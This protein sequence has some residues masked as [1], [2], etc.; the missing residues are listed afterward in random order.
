MTHF[1]SPF[2]VGC[3]AAD[4][5]AV[6]KM[7][8]ALLGGKPFEGLE[9]DRDTVAVIARLPSGEMVEIHAVDDEDEP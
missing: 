9:I 1:K 2:A 5:P 4:V 3:T 8:T 6:A 7:L